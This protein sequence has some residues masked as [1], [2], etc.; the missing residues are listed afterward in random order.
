MP[1]ADTIAAIATAAGRAGIGVIR[2]S[3][4]NLAIFAQSLLGKLPAPR[5]ATL[6]GFKDAH[7][8]LIDQGLALYFPAP[9]SYTGE[10]VLELHGHGGNAVLRSMLQR[11]LELGARM[12][13]PGEFTQRAFLND[14]LDLAQ[15]EAVADLIDA[16]TA[17]AAKSAARSLSGD[18]SAHIHSL[19]KEL[20]DLRMLVEATL[21]FPEEEIDF[22]EASNAHGRLDAV[23]EKLKLV[24]TASKQGSLLRSGI[25]VAIIGR[26]NAGKSSLLNQLAGEQL[27]IVTDVPG[28]TR[29]AVRAPIQIEGV[30]L[31]IIDTAGLRDTKDVVE[32]LG[33]ERSWA[34]AA[35][36]SI[37]LHVIDATVGITAEDRAIGERLVERSVIQVF[38]KIDLLDGPIEVVADVSQTRVFISAKTGQDID[39]LKTELLRVAGWQPTGEGVFSARERHMRALT[40]AES[41]LQKARLHRSQLELLAEELRL[42]QVALGA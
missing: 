21:D 26:P 24:F 31:H 27:A 22:L 9:A 23:E 29:D 2:V 10:D 18:F 12:A 40:Q 7:G 16:A 8:E 4:S 33:V 11:C 13:E 19:V 5:L 42:A 28:T 38:N 1:N 34:A 37:V 25:Q 3:G 35:E 36:A 6:T 20:I 41:H 15:A 32:G 14:K 30:P 39:C 17:E